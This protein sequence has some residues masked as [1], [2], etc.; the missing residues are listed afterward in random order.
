M[1]TVTLFH[2]RSV[3][4]CN[5]KVWSKIIC[6]VLVQQEQCDSGK[7][8]TKADAFNTTTDVHKFCMSISPESNCCVVQPTFQSNQCC[9]IPLMFVWLFLFLFFLCVCFCF[10]AMFTLRNFLRSLCKQIFSFTLYRNKV[11]PS[12]FVVLS[13]VKKVLPGKRTFISSA[14]SL[15]PIMSDTIGCGHT[16]EVTRD[17][18]A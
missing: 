18:K 13:C 17:L 2:I 15:L 3:S 6:Q 5:T 1:Q 12:R 10:F 4:F 16:F 9:Y 11:F 7:T 14:A 8:N